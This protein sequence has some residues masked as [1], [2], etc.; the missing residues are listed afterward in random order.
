M[1]FLTTARLLM[2]MQEKI[3]PFHYRFEETGILHIE[4]VPD[5]GVA[6]LF[7]DAQRMFEPR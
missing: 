7:N 5:E 4:L 3:G 2:D 6:E 1:D